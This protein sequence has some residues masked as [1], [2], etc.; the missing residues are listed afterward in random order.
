MSVLMFFNDGIAHAMSRRV[1]NQTYYYL[2]NEQGGISL[3]TYHTVGLNTF[4]NMIPYLTGND[5]LIFNRTCQEHLTTPYFGIP[6]LGQS[7]ITMVFILDDSLFCFERV[8]LEI[9]G[10]NFLVGVCPHLPDLRRCSLMTFLEGS[11]RKAK[12]P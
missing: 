7:M 10:E 6:R 2:R 1:L 4:P 9:S 11:L 5:F 12:H 3:D 8:L